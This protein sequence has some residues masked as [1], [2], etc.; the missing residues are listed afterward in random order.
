MNIVEKGKEGERQICRLLNV[1]VQDVAKNFDDETR[2]ALKKIVQ[3][4]QNQSA[5]G[6]GDIYILGLA[7]EVKRQETLSVEAWWRQAVA[8]TSPRYSIPVLMYRQNN[9]KWH[10]VMEMNLPHLHDNKTT[11]VRG[12]ISLES[13][14]EWF[15]QWTLQKIT[16]GDLAYV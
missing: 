15:Q 6:G 12:E 3:R 1:V 11:K 8:S 7:I 10:V 13:F 5:V 2:Q 16:E 9:R 4:N 14:L